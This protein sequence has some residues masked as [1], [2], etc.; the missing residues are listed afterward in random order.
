MKNLRT[1]M[2]LL[3]WEQEDVLQGRMEDLGRQEQRRKLIQ[4]KGRE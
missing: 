2:N 4:E 1:D 3:P